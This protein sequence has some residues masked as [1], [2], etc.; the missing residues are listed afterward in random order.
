MISLNLDNHELARTYDAV[1][2]SQFRSGV[3]LIE[4]LDV[5][6]GETVLDIGC[7]TGRLAR[8]VLETVGPEGRVTGIDPLPE[9]IA[10]A[11]EKNSHPNGEFHVGG[12]EDL[13]VVADN[14]IDVVYLSAVF[15]WIADKKRTLTEIRR[16]LKPGGRVGLTTNAKE[17]VQATT[18][19]LVT[20]RVLGQE[21][22]RSLV[23]ADDFAPTRYGVTATQLVELFLQAGFTVA[24][25]HI[26]ANQRHYE[27]GSAIVS[28]VE[29]STF[30]NYLSHV[31]EEL[32]DRARQDLAAEFETLRTPEGIG[33]HLYTLFA[34]AEK[35]A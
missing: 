30:G 26:L 18:L 22:Y 25:L 28:F 17:L 3:K 27:S 5:K 16:V 6:R 35:E 32:R 8:H 1:S 21:P 29:S 10:I 20:S 34:V 31:P 19:R 24:D 4:S 23:S 2:D 11:V 13:S 12:A 9:R 15:H 7:G 33:I 14:S